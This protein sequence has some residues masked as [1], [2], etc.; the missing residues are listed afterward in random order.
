MSNNIRNKLDKLMNKYK[1]FLSYSHSQDINLSPL[2]QQSL[3]KFAKKWYQTRRIRIFRDETNL[4][5]TPSLWSSIESALKDAEYFIYLASPEAAGSKWV[6]QEVDWWLKN[7]NKNK[8]L[9]VLTNGNIK[10]NDDLNDFDRLKSN[11][12]PENIFSE[13]DSEPLYIDMRWANNSKKENLSSSPKFQNDMASLASILLSQDKDDLIGYNA[14]QIKKRNNFLRLIISSLI[15]LLTGSM[16]STYY[17]I[18][19]KKEAE[20]QTTLAEKSTH[21]AILQRNS[22]ERSE[23]K[24]INNQLEANLNLARSYEQRALFAM[25]QADAVQ[26]E[27]WVSISNYKRAWLYAFEAKKLPIPKGKKALRKTALSQLTNLSER[28]ISPEIKLFIDSYNE[29]KNYTALTYNPSGTVL[30]SVSSKDNSIRLW[31]VVSGKVIKYLDGH[32][33]AINEITYDP[34]GNFLA[35]SSKDG[36]IRIW[37]VANEKKAININHYSI[38]KSIAYDPTGRILATG[39]DD[40]DVRLWDSRTGELMHVLNGGPSA[41]NHIMFSPNGKV[42]ALASNDSIRLLSPKSGKLLRIFDNYSS[43]SITSLAYSPDGSIIASGTFDQRIHLWD[44]Q[45]GDL[46]KTLFAHSGFIEDLTFSPDGTKLA[47]ASN[48]PFLNGSIDIWDIEAGKMIHSY[49]NFSRYINSLSYSPDG[50]YLASTSEDE[51]IQLWDTQPGKLKQTLELENYYPSILRLAYSSDAKTIASASVAPEIILWDVDTG[52]VK[53]TLKDIQLN[54][55]L[56]FNRNGIITTSTDGSQSIKI[57]NSSSG[58]L[59]KTLEGKSIKGGLLSHAYSPDG[60]TL[61]S[62][63][64]IDNTLSFWDVQT[65]KLIRSVTTKNYYGDLAYS[66]DGKYLAGNESSVGIFLLNS[67]TGEVVESLKTDSEISTFLF[68]PDG[69]FIASAS[70]DNTIYIWDLRSLKIIKEFKSHTNSVMSLAFSPNGKR[71]ASGS[72]DRTIKIWDMESGKLQ[73]TYEGHYNDV[74]A[75][76]YSP[77]GLTLISGSRDGSIRVWD[78][79]QLTTLKLFN[80]YDPFKVSEALQFI[81]KMSLDINTLEFINKP[82]YN[83]PNNNKLRA[84]LEMPEPNQTKIEQL[85]DWL[86]KHCAHINKVKSKACSNN[87]S[88]SQ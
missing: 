85:V 50:K 29:N 55:A 57:W 38:A 79:S 17:A 30:A 10:W 87:I 70:F 71:L 68:S 14:V 3:E 16:F 42:L 18:V 69:E 73:D 65:S 34:T 88:T 35:S 84:L 6:K 77:D 2:L 33:D 21:E 4:S 12:I 52:K 23:K 5:V 46:L 51:G 62:F 1:A 86:D 59:I 36:S 24:A 40:S 67:D 31:D 74:S 83:Y 41:I 19:Q 15:I 45:T 8:L 27:D 9:I 66:P 48:I 60:K 82:T 13:F 32:S 56:T 61:A 78:N 80:N 58:S 22:A 26:K 72:E 47:A 63:G 53:H 49:R 37:D 81:W 64:T 11:S 54:S 75:L 7:K 44:S 43:T 25:S 20:L 28:A 76:E 39:S